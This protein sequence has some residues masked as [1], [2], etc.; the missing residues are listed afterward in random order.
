VRYATE[1][2]ADRLAAV[3]EAAVGVLAFAGPARALL[4]RWRDDPP[5][6]AAVPAN[7]HT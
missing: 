1:P 2:A 7:W 4:A 6:G 5:G 3:G